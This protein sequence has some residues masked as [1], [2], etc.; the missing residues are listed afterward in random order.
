MNFNLK[1]VLFGEMSPQ[2]KIQNTSSSSTPKA[3]KKPPKYDPS[4]YREPISAISSPRLVNGELVPDLERNWDKEI[5]RIVDVCDRH[6]RVEKFSL[7]VKKQRIID[8][9]M[10]CSLRTLQM[11]LGA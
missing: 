8:V 1:T 7:E 10:S 6:S 11:P 9:L 3:L 2:V 5:G 4:E